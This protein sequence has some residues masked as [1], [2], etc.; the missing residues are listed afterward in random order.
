[1]ADLATLTVSFPRAREDA[2]AFRRAAVEV[3]V[4]TR[5]A[6]RGVAAEGEGAL[7]R[8]APT[9]THLLRSSIARVEIGRGSRTTVVVGANAT[10][11]LTGFDYVP[12]TRFGHRVARIYPRVDRAPATVVASGRP[13]L[14]G[15]RGALRFVIG[16]EVFFRHSVR[17]YH[18]AVDWVSQADPVI[19]AAIASQ[20][21][22]ID[23]RVE[24]TLRR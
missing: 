11:P 5:D 15:G 3:Q 1:M 21:A 16:G 4:A 22:Q 18:P 13:R 12:V 24:R 20:S 10:D 8:F 7:K 2:R 17:G 14:G 6:T 19:D 23:A 9:R